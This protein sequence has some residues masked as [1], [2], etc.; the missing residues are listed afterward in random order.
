[1]EA[2]GPIGNHRRLASV[3]TTVKHLSFFAVMVVVVSA[4]AGS[5]QP[6]PEPSAS[7]SAEV[8]A[9]ALV[10]LITVDHTFG[11]GP[12]PFTEYLIQAKIDPFAGNPTGGERPTRPLTSEEQAAIEFALGAYGPVRWIDDPADWRTDDL[13]PSIEGAVILGVGEPILNG[14]T[15][16]VPVSLWC[17]GLCGTWLTYRLDLVDGAWTVTGIEGPISIS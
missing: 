4:C 16:L 1:M 9:A 15:A 14:D 5:P 10:Q 11:E 6:P 3:Q 8:M 12:P 17:G 13:L 7:A 2:P